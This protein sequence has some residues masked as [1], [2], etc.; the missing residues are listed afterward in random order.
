MTNV[1]FVCVQNAGRSQMSRAFFE[2]ASAGRRLEGRSAGT[3]PADEID[4][5]VVEAMA[6]LGF[7]LKG[8]RPATLTPDLGEWADVV[9]T[10]GCGDS[11]PWVPGTKHID[12][13]LPDPAGRPIAE[14]RAIRDEV[15]D[16]V[17]AMVEALSPEGAGQEPDAGR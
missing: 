4:P 12:W 11:C 15:R 5:V 2:S 3:R 9:V 17:G 14:V 8:L 6:E 16:R 7:D 1:L 13:D 10:M